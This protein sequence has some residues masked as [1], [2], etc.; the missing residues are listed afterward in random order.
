MDGSQNSSCIPCFI[1][2]RYGQNEEGMG[3]GRGRE[4]RLVEEGV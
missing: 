4:G 2:G 3:R 1:G